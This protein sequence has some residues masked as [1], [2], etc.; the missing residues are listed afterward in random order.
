MLLNK[1]AT[2]AGTLVLGL[3]AAAQTAPL[4]VENW[5]TT[6]AD[7]PTPAPA[8]L[9][10]G[11][12]GPDQASTMQTNVLPSGIVDRTA[13]LMNVDTSGTPFNS[14]YNAGA[15]R[16]GAFTRGIGSCG[17][18]ATEGCLKFFSGDGVGATLILH[19]HL[20]VAQV[21]QNL[22]FA[23]LNAGT[24]NPFPLTL[25]YKAGG[26][27]YHAGA[28]GPDAVDA[29]TYSVD[30]SGTTEN[31]AF[32]FAGSPSVTDLWL[33][34]NP[35][36]APGYQRV[37]SIDVELCCGYANVPEPASMGLLAVALLGLGGALRRRA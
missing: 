4:E 12:A 29:T 8:G 14:S 16:A 1:A 2:L 34:Y 20:Q 33:S 6:F 32:S 7:P 25:D 35:S 30:A 36:T 18:S 9:H 22:Q 17:S 15:W 24:S 31:Y 28:S 11:G 21:L 27:T 10:V 13:S 23:V 3:S 37:L 19:Y 5:A 26:T